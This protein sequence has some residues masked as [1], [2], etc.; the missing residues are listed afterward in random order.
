M[1][2]TAGLRQVATDDRRPTQTATN[3]A[4]DNRID[5]Q[6]QGCVRRTLAA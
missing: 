5:S 3:M 4:Y 6:S 1:A 2:L